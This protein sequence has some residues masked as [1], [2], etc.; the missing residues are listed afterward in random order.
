MAS[1]SPFLIAQYE[2]Q[3]LT[4][5]TAKRVQLLYKQ[6]AQDIER[7]LRNLRMLTPSD[8]LKKVYLENLLN[9]INKSSD[10]FNRL[11][12]STVIDAGETSGKLAVEAGNKAMQNAGLS[13]KG[14]YSYIPRQQVENIASGKL[15]GD[16]WSLS[17]S[18]WKSGLRTKSD[19]E[20]VVAKG[21]MQNKP[22]KDIA[23]DLTKY[24]DPTARKPWDWSK[25]YPGTA[26]QVD[27][28]AQRLAR[29]MIQ[30]S[31]QA[32]L[33]QS[34]LYNPFC[35]GVI[36]YSVGI[37]GRTCELCMERDGNVFPVKD[38]PLDHPN[39]LCYFEPVL[40]N[41][42]AIA[43]RLAN[44]TN[45]IA[46][47][48]LDT[49]VAKAFGLDPKS[50]AGKNAVATAKEST[51]R[52]IVRPNKQLKQKQRHK[53]VEGKDISTTWTRRS[54]KFDFEIE[55][56]INAQGFDGKPRIVSAKEFD[57][58]V[59]D[60][61]FIA[62]RTYSAE[63]Q[64]ILEAYRKQ[65]YEGKWYVDCGTG[66]AQY[67]QGMYCA[68]DYTGTLSE[69]IKAEMRHYQELG[70]SRMRLVDF[71]QK[72]ADARSKDANDAFDKVISNA[73]LSKIER[74]LFRA[75]KLYTASDAEMNEAWEIMAKM[76]KEERSVINKRFNSILSKAESARNSISSM[77]L[78]DYA[79]KK[80]MKLRAEPA[81]YT[82]TLTLDPSAKIV[83]YK[84]IWEEFQGYQ[85]GG[86][87]EAIKSVVKELG[88]EGS[89]RAVAELRVNITLGRNVS[90]S[91]SA[92]K[93]YNKF[94]TP[95]KK[96]KAKK[97]EKQILEEVE[98]RTFKDVGSYAASKG[99]DA[100]N[101]VGHG[102]SGSY[103]VILNRTKVIIKR[104]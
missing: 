104:P 37:H 73:S 27:Y 76:S 45:G 5:Q 30:H 103:T 9:D 80:G 44:W 35:K 66:G 58:A 39:G 102:E 51:T 2:K 74:L 93:Q 43:D 8:S 87:R 68:A 83:D 41:M 20:K 71:S 90:S 19:M 6:S 24:V 34:Q 61:K 4:K 85:D 94:M 100:I 36:W 69:G 91:K 42:D 33:V 49:Y 38:L 59:K 62:Q 92:L 77:S 3:A 26:Q 97:L 84:K 23:D 79:K 52:N 17:K 15:Y 82:E 46:D 12:R 7:K 28:N 53:V 47:P 78:E 22:I 11:V 67:G 98:K 21:L 60:S 54:G 86:V 32:S 72:V 75:N 10:S 88:A 65:L 99:Y 96:K 31:F 101:A 40:D 63:S 70:E 18:I 29:T 13:I 64:E 95:D 14:A 50:L 16:K 89:E 48:E 25:V 81:H 57:A 1:N 56:V 55:D